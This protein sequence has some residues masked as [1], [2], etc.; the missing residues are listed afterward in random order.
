MEQRKL[1][2]GDV[3]R[4]SIQGAKG[5]YYPD[6]EGRAIMVREDC[7][8]DR[9]IGWNMCSEFMAFSAPVTAFSERDRYDTSGSKMVIWVANNG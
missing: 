9:Q 3:V 7:V 6:T 5:F 4:R 2:R 1:K 8:A